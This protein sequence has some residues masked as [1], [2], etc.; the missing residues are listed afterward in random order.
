MSF[1]WDAV[2]GAQGYNI[3]WGIAKDKLYQSWQVYDTTEH[4]MRSL[5]R[6]TPYYF[7]IEAFSENGISV[8]SDITYAE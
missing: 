1:S 5:D 3:R 7:T 2:E 8:K 6:D 4:F